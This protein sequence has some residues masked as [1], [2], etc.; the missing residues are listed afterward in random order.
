MER[1]KRIEKARVKSG[2]GE[3]TSTKRE[4][5]IRNGKNDMTGVTISGKQEEGIREQ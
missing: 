4:E 1:G 2:N 3:D 5:H